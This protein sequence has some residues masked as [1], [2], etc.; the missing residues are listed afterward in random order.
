MMMIIPAYTGPFRALG[1]RQGLKHYAVSCGH[2]VRQSFYWI[3]RTE[4]PKPFYL[5]RFQVLTAASMMF[6]AVLWVVLPCKMIVDRRFRGAYCLHHQG[7]VRT[8]EKSV[9]NHFTRQYNPEDSSE[10]HT[11]RRENLKSHMNQL[12]S[13]EWQIQYQ[14]ALGTDCLQSPHHT[15]Q[16]ASPFGDIHNLLNTG[17]CV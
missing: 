16:T 3:P 13:H 9:D 14:V 10:H 2:A 1:R 17:A 8:S 15:T 5:V 12:R 7:W 6:R 4:F 11:R